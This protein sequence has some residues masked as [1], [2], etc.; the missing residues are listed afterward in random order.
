M[1]LCSDPV[2]HVESSSNGRRRVVTVPGSRSDAL[3]T[4]PSLEH[5]R[6]YVVIVVV[7]AKGRGTRTP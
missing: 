5:H 3:A 6:A 1:R 7:L 4:E 2:A